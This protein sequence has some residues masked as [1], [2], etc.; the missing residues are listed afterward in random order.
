VAAGATGCGNVTDGPR[1]A[2]GGQTSTD[3]HGG[4]EASRLLRA[5]PCVRE[6][7]GGFL[8]GAGS[9]VWSHG[10]RGRGLAEGPGSG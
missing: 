9:N 10:G 7:D 4:G 1:F 3:G 5:I 8:R 2:E 6:S